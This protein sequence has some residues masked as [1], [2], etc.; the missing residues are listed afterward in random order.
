MPATSLAWRSLLGPLGLLPIG[1]L[2]FFVLCR[3]LARVLLR[4]AG[5]LERLLASAIGTVAAMALVVRLL[6][7]W[8]IMGPYP[9]LGS[10]LVAWLATRGL[11]A[12]QNR[13]RRDVEQA[14]RRMPATRPLLAAT[15]ALAVAVVAVGAAATAAWL[16]PIWQW[17]A[18]G[19]H[20]PFVNFVL[21]RGSAADVP[22]EARFLSDFP[23]G[24]EWVFVAW[25]A[26][27]PDDRLLDLAQIPFGILGAAA[28]AHLARRLG[29]Q[30]AEAASAGALW[31][32]IPIV[33]L[34][35]PTN[36]IDV[37][38]AAYLLCAL[39]WMVGRPTDRRPIFAALALGLFLG[40]KPGAPVQTALCLL[41]LLFQAIRSKRY[42]EWAVACGIV[43]LLG[44]ESYLVNLWRHHNPAWP[45]AF[46]IGPLRFAG[47]CAMD[48]LL[49]SGAA[50]P[51]AEGSLVHR[52]W[53]AWTAVGAL[54]TFDMKLGGFGPLFLLVLPLSLVACL[55]RPTALVLLL[56][57]LA[58]PDPSIARYTMALPAC[59]LALTATLLQRAS[60]PLRTLGAAVGA[61][62]ACVGLATAW[63]GLRG[64]GPSLATYFSLS[65]SERAQ[66]V[67]PSGSPVPFV[68]ARAR[69][70]RNETAAYQGTFEFSY[71]LW[72]DDLANRVTRLEEDGLAADDIAWAQLEAAHVRLLVARDGGALA[73]R[74]QDRAWAV[75]DRVRGSPFLLLWREA[76][77]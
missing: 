35:L 8:G 43:V 59:A 11:R 4:Q 66:A 49:H 29:A 9:L 34:Q 44:G 57:A 13:S 10:G 19:Y 6:A 55:R 21:Q 70:G 69:L 2:L 31:L 26:L 76:A 52:V 36:Y 22:A 33:F 30:P 74:A 41:V 23:H 77:P 48:A 61:T 5:P 51:H 65:P 32:A 42:A 53:M 24:V 17:D 47:P 28:T 63:P 46:S 7:A 39:A 62:M 73:K 40:S 27:L 50:V 18:L 67:G 60:L 64:E 58:A 71:L 45:A 14:A 75:L 37:A 15:P 54:P 68:Q 72:R 56:I 16:L 3:E 38:S 25:R 1:L 20:L 12:I